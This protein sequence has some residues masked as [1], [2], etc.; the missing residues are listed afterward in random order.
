MQSPDTAANFAAT[1]A[2]NAVDINEA[3]EALVAGAEA[4][5]ADE[6]GQAAFDSQLAMAMLNKGMM[7]GAKRAM[8]KADLNRLVNRN[9]SL[10]KEK[11]DRRRAN[12]QAKASKKRNRK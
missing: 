4:T 10:Q 8:R 7:R 9:I 12:K 5:S 11:D 2:D 3:A 1:L 6:A